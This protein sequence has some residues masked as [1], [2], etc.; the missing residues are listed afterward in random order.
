MVTICWVLFARY[1]NKHGI[2]Q[3]YNVD[4]YA[5]HMYYTD[6]S[7]GFEEIQMLG[8][9]CFFRICVL[10][11]IGKRDNF[12]EVIESTVMKM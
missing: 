4:V 7:W 5:K 9:R 11:Q 6:I 2:L 8:D 3:S 1:F 10:Y 12:L